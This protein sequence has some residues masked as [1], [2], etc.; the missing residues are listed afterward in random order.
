MIES[1][2]DGKT[3]DI[4]QDNIEQ[5]KQLFPEIVTENKID[6]D[7]LKDVLGEE[8]DDSTE[9]YDFTWKGKHETVK[10]S[11]TPSEG[12]LR[13][14]KKDSKN[15]DT[16][17]NLYIEGDNLEVLKLLQKSYYGKIKMIYLDPPYNNRQYPPNYHVLETIAKYDYPEIHGISGMRDYSNQISKFCRKREVKRALE[18][19]VSNAKFK[20]IFLS[21]STDGLLSIKDIEEIF[22]KYGKKNTYSMAKPIEYRKYKSIQKQTKK[23]SCEL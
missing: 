13:P 15:W 22:K 6:F 11:Q 14:S 16:T 7:K 1:T 10:I 18:D 2:L 3:K 19:I 9:R 12:T 17:E 20:Y 8:I 4:T 5:L 23:S 21:Y